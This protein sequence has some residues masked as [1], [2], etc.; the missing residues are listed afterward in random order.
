M[1]AIS[2]QLSAVSAAGGVVRDPHGS[3]S[4]SDALVLRRGCKDTAAR[5]G[6]T[7]QRPT[8]SRLMTDS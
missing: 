4:M 2:H 8:D 6:R 5:D 1:R 3:E 7:H